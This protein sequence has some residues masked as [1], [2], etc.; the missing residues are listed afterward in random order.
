MTE[1]PNYYHSNLEADMSMYDHLPY[2]INP[3]LCDGTHIGLHSGNVIKGFFVNYN[4]TDKHL[5]IPSE[6]KDYHNTIQNNPVS[7]S[8][9]TENFSTEETQ[10]TIEDSTEDDFVENNNSVQENS[11]KEQDNSEFNAEDFKDELDDNEFS[12]DEEIYL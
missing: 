1:D 3:E 6:V 8:V 5:I 9:N 7:S 4:Y 2:H 11:N 12:G 10:D